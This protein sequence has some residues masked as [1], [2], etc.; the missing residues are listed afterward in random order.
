MTQFDP[1]IPRDL[2][3][4]LGEEAVAISTAGKYVGPAGLV[5]ISAQVVTALKKTTHYGP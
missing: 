1:R 4:R 3:V 5:D 2:A